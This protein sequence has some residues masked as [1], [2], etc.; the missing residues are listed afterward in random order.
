MVTATI[1]ARDQVLAARTEVLAAIEDFDPGAGGGGLDVEAVRDAIGATLVGGAGITVNVDDGG[2]TVTIA[3][4]NASKT[5]VGL[6]NVDNTSDA[7]KPVSTAQQEALDLKAPLSALGSAA[8]QSSSAFATAAQG[9]KADTAVQPGSLGSA[10]SQSTS[11]FATAAQGAKADSAVQPAA[12][13]GKADLVNGVVPLAQLPAAVSVMVAVAD[14]NGTS[15]PAR[16][17]AILVI[18]SSLAYDNTVPAP[19]Q[20]TS[21]DIWLADKDTVVAA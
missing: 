7:N 19:P 13:A 6:G 1:T 17:D 14:W 18:W 2:N 5:E 12:L 9:A 20:M 21:H 8:G 11:A 10:A 3:R 4:T 15:W 16:P